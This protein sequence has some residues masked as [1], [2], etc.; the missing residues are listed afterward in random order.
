MGYW[1]HCEACG[2]SFIAKGDARFCSWACI[3]ANKITTEIAPGVYNPVPTNTAVATEHE[4]EFA[5]EVGGER[6]YGSGCAPGMCGDVKLDEWFFELKTTRPDSSLK[7]KRSFTLTTELLD[8]ADREALR[9]CQ[10]MAMV[11]RIEGHEVVV[12]DKSVFLGLI[13][14]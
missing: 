14:E 2:R 6:V 8:K 4:L 11:V 5:K 10:K 3:N 12:L 1:R 13:D 7:Q 9:S